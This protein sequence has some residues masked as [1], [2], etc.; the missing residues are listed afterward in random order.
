MKLVIDVELRLSKEYESLHKMALYDYDD[1]YLEHLKDLMA[2]EAERYL[3]SKAE[4]LITKA[5]TE[6][7]EVMDEM[8]RDEAH[9]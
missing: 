5:L 8:A 9:A 3:R 2:E 7:R 1:Y 6:T 4:A